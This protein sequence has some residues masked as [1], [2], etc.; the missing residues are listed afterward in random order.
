MDIM[1]KFLRVSDLLVDLLLDDV[2][3]LDEMFTNTQFMPATHKNISRL[4]EFLVVK[5]KFQPIEER[6]TSRDVRI[7][8]KK[9]MGPKKKVFFDQMDKHGVKNVFTKIEK[10]NE[11]TMLWKQYWLLHN[12]LREEKKSVFNFII[13]YSSDFFKNNCNN[14]LNI[15]VDTYGIGNMTPYLH[16]TCLHL[17]EMHRKHGNLNYYAT[18]G[19]EKLNDLSTKDF[20]RSTNKSFTFIKQMLER[21]ARL[22]DD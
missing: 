8:M 19:L 2:F 4:S 21:D 22:E 18:E 14:L 20:F 15:F 12:K 3:R 6:A 1:H 13:N 5:C 17:H 11:I 10:K 9:M 7:H 16:V